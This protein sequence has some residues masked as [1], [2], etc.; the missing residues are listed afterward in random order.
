MI[1]IR[2]AVSDDA[3]AIAGMNVRSW[4]ASYR[5][6]ISDEYLDGL[7]PRDRQAFVTKVLITGPPYHTKVATD[8]DNVVGFVMLGP[9]NDPSLDPTLVHEL[10]SLYIEP[11]LIGTGLGRRLIVEALR[12]LRAGNWTTAV[13]WTLRD[14]ARTCR[15][16]EAAGWWPDGA[17]KVEEIPKGNPVTQIRY[18]IDLR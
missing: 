10:Y 18:R 11:E 12:H 3:E 15:F 4:Q 7:D 2:N 1:E 9:P 5:G 13:L 8:A 14:L 17:E 16:Y 6:I